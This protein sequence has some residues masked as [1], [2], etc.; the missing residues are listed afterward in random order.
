MI[1]DAG[2]S[3]LDEELNRPT[4]IIEYRETSIQDHA[5][6]AANSPMIGDLLPDRR[7]N[8]KL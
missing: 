3:I 5:A 2:Y 7:E 8:I 6:A 1:L 4:F